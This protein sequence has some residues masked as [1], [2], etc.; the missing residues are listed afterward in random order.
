[1]ALNY[2]TEKIVDQSLVWVDQSVRGIPMNTQQ[3]GKVLSL[4]CEC[5]VWYTVIVGIPE[6]TQDTID[7][8]YKRM[9]MSDKLTGYLRLKYGK[10]DPITYHELEQYIGLRTNA[11]AMSKSLFTKKLYRHAEDQLISAQKGT[12]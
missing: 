8:F 9:W 1:M 7:E 4:T 11:S 5:L 10:P 2:Y 6:L 3:E 12:K